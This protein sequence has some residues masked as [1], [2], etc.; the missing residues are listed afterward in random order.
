MRKNDFIVWI[1]LST[2]QL[3]LYQRFLYMPEVKEILNTSKSP[4]VSDTGDS[5]DHHIHRWRSTDGQCVCDRR[6]SLC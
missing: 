2:V 5:R 3:E 4:L 1:S 6:R